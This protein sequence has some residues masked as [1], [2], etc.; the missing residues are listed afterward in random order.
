L[1]EHREDESERDA[2]EAA[3]ENGEGLEE[4][5][6]KL[7]LDEDQAYVPNGVFGKVGP[8]V[9]D[10]D[11]EAN[12]AVPIEAPRRA[13]STNDGQER[14]E[15]KN[16][17]DEESVMGRMGGRK[18]VERRGFGERFTLNSFAPPGSRS[19]PSTLTHLPGLFRAILNLEPLFSQTW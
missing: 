15:E 18:K 13:H 2:A 6:S 19:A 5:T 9:S 3:K 11:Q 1:L 12:E 4:A 7:F 8:L 10:V 16:E 14:W 17:E